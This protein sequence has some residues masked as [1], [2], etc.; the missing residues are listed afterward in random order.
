MLPWVKAEAGDVFLRILRSDCLKNPDRHQV[1][2]FGKRCAHTDRTI[3]RPVEISR[4]PLDR[5][6]FAGIDCDRCIVDDGGRGETLLQSCRVD[7]WLETRARLTAR[8]SD[9]IELVTVEVEAADQRPNRA[10]IG[11][12]RYE[13]R[14][15]FGQLHDLPVALFVLLHANQGAP[16]EPRLRGSLGAEEPRRK[17]QSLARDF[18]RLSALA[19]CSDFTRTRLQDYRGNDVF[20]LRLVR[21]GVFHLLLSNVLRKIEV[22][23]GPAVALA[24]VVFQG[25]GPD[26]F[27]RCLLVRYRKGR[28]DA[29][30]PGIGILLVRVVNCLP[31]HFRKVVRLGRVPGEFL[32]DRNGLRAG[33][34]EL[35]FVD[36]AKFE[37][38][39]QDIYLTL[40]GTVHVDKRIVARRGLWQASQHGD[41]R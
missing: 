17:P 10:G 26:S 11:V 3:E 22:T 6:R 23:L 39:V 33:L 30:A 14:L 16:L 29:K 1:L 28:I 15:D 32:C 12:K 34:L 13:C 40:L 35:L 4:L 24:L 41:F 37:H 8:L 36:I 5:A 18:Y 31:N 38:P 21:Q 9:M 7:K 2:G 20:A 25:S 27:V 19:V